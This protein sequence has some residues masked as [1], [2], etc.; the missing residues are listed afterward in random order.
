MAHRKASAPR[1][2]GPRQPRKTTR[3]TTP[4]RADVKRPAPG[5]VEQPRTFR[6]GVIPGA[7]PG[8]WVDRWHERKPHVQLELVPL[9]VAEQR[10]ALDEGRVDAA[11]VRRPLEEDGL[12]VIAMYDEVP[13]VVVSSDSDLTVVDELE[14]PELAGSVLIV[15]KDDVLGPLALPGTIPP[16]FDAPETTEDAIATV[17]TGVGVTVVPMSLARL[18]HRRDVT[19]RPLVGGPVAPVAF[20]WLREHDSEDVQDF[21]GILRG[22]TANSSR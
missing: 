19:Y 21:V 17:A 15:P 2:G 16:V 10:A 4:R 13:V 1:G 22:R 8:R 14:A 7:T 20:A 5:P 11:I 12:H 9:V 3:S 6:L 18:H